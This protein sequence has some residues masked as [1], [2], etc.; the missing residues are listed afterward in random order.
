MEKN[1]TK[2]KKAS[3]HSIIKGNNTKIYIIMD[4][5]LLGIL[6][7][8][9]V[10]LYSM[11][12][13]IT[14]YQ[15]YYALYPFLS[16]IYEPIIV[17]KEKGIILEKLIHIADWINDSLLKTEYIENK[18]MIIETNKVF[19]DIVN[20]DVIQNMLKHLGAIKK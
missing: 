3:I 10:F 13:R 7:N 14:E 20:D 5:S 17:E 18:Y 4:L 12:R 9:L 1:L 11:I 8:Q 16:Q 15:D 6:E 19:N 2:Y